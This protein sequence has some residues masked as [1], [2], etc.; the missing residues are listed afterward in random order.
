MPRV[1][2]HHSLPLP[3]G[4]PRHLRSTLANAISLADF[5][6]T[7]T[8][9]WAADSFNPR[10]RLQAELE[11]LRR[12]ASLLRGEILVEDI[13]MERIEPHRR[14]YYPAMERLAIVDLG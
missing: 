9:S 8:L 1:A 5:A 2:Y 3:L 11:R 14:P 12:E 7:R 4:W 10:L 6:F 13:P